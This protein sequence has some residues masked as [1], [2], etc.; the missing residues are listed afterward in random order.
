MASSPSVPAPPAGES[1]DSIDV[2]PPTPQKPTILDA[3]KTINPIE[4]LQRLPSMPCARYSLLFGMVAGASVGGLR[5]IF[6]RTGR[7]TL[8]GGPSR[9]SQVVAAANWAV[10][11]WAIGSLGAW[12]TCRS[13]QTAEAAR[14]A[15]LISEVKAR[16]AAKA[17][18]AAGPV[19]D[20]VGGI[21]IGEKGKEMLKEKQ[22]RA[23]GGDEAAQDE[24][25]S[26]GD[27]SWWSGRI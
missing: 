8:A 25:S 13:R 7:G 4:D 23:T 27:K 19:K 22:R 12:H 17:G 3:A 16:Q 24:A 1:S 6:S 15:A 2:L 26:K 10:G 9:G 21:L 14:M 5:F 18:E 11:A 20:R